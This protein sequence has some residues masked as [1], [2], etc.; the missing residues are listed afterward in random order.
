MP[1]HPRTGNR[2]LNNRAFQQPVGAGHRRDNG[3]ARERRGRRKEHAPRRPPTPAR[4]GLR[5]FRVVGEVPAALIEARLARDA[6]ACTHHHIHACAGAMPLLVD[7]G[8]QAER[9]VK[10]QTIVNCY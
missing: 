10:Q 2:P 5:R 3:V 7:P 6:L 4:Q 8:T 9:V 1:V